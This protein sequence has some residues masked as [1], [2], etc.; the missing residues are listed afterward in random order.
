M[1]PHGWVMLLYDGPE[2]WGEGEFSG[3]HSY[4]RLVRWVAVA[5]PCHERKMW[6]RVKSEGAPWNIRVYRSERWANIPCFIHVRRRKRT[7]R[8]RDFAVYVW[9]CDVLFVFGPDF[10]RS[11]LAAM[12]RLLQTVVSGERGAPLTFTKL[13]PPV[14]EPHLDERTG[15]FI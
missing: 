7:A 15:T 14:L 10:L 4:D 9:C 11:R 5:L 8:K 13:C 12:W 2:H 3:Q 6:R 1:N